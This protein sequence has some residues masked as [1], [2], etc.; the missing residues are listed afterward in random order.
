MKIL[1]SEN[2]LIW[3]VHIILSCQTHLAELWASVKLSSRFGAFYGSHIGLQCEAHVCDAQAGGS[4]LT[5]EWLAPSADLSYLYSV[6][7]PKS[8]C[9]LYGLPWK[10]FETLWGTLPG[11]IQGSNAINQVRSNR[12]TVAEYLIVSFHGEFAA[13][14][15]ISP[16]NVKSHNAHNY[17]LEKTWVYSWVYN[18]LT[19]MK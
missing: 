9:L 14:T 10:N 19:Q 6:T 13:L 15:T 5:V 17:D 12:E 7:K 11:N 1:F 18:V 2:C 3:Y 8:L 4:I 16:N